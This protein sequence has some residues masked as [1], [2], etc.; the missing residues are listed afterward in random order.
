M[1]I[2]LHIFN[3]LRDHDCVII[4]NFGALVCRNI[5]AKISSDKTKI[6][7]P[8]KEISF[9]RSLVKNDCLL[10]NQI[11]NSERVSYEKAEKK[12]ANWVNKNLKRLE[13]Q[14][15]IEIKNIGSIHLKDAKFIF[16]PDP[17]SIVLKSSFGLK[18]YSLFFTYLS[19]DLLTIGLP[20][21]Q[22]PDSIIISIL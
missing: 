10:I 1:K 21:F 12:I 7:P 4:P 19:L 16:T 9:N 3:L 18:T 13:S 22:V 8:N 15:T 14:E 11:T 5:S 2:S 20:S 6:Y 17:N